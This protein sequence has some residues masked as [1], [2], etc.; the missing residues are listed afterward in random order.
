MSGLDPLAALSAAVAGAQSGVDIAALDLGVDI[1]LLQ[2]QIAIGDILEATVLP[3]QDGSDYVSLAGHTVPAQLPPGINP[4]QSIALQVT[5]FTPTALLVRNLGIA[6]PE[7]PIVVPELPA[8]DPA[9]PQA[10]ILTTTVPAAPPPPVAT[11][12][13]PTAPVNAGLPA[14]APPAPP[15][16]TVPPA[17]QAQPSAPAAPAPP[18]PGVVAPSPAVFA[19]AAVRQAATQRAAADA[20]LEEPVQRFA[21]DVEA[22]IAVAR[23]STLPPPA[24]RGGPSPAAPPPPQQASPPPGTLAPA[25]TLAQLNRTAVPPL[26]TQANASA[27]AAESTPPDPLAQ[28]APPQPPPSEPSGAAPRPLPATP[29]AAILARLRVP[30]SPLTLAAARTVTTAAQALSTTY[31]KLDALLASVASDPR[32]ATLRTLLDFAGTFD[33]RNARALP[34]QINA[35]VSNVVAGPESKLAQIVRAWSQ[36]TAAEAARVAEQNAP[37]ASAP[38]SGAPALPQTG[39]RAQSP[40]IPAPAAAATN[41]QAQAA[42]RTVALDHD[43]KTAI[44]ALIANPPRDASAQVVAALRD[45]LGATTAVQLNVLNA[46]A[47]DPSAITIPLPAFFFEG[48]RPAQLRINKDAPNGKGGMDADNFHIAFVLDTATLGTVAIDVQTVGRAVNVEVKTERGAAADRFKA[49]LGDLRSRLEG[50]RYTVSA[51]S[52]DVAPTSRTKDA[53]PPQQ[54]DAGASKTSNVDMRA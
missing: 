9:T 41:A 18:P 48:G 1:Q 43:V 33:L 10:A 30:E 15:A 36:A 7:T 16:P 24:A 40:A 37:A 26:V 12:A 45:A 25:S 54:V 20:S 44:L 4:G 28:D 2:T 53:K 6:T 46:Q 34:E 39:A 5:G 42:E 8:Q 27:V 31:A 51:I 13:N 47:N 29:E 50:L 17:S 23:A 11:P 19:A 49:T 22:R 38:A 35:F 3:P 32:A 21:D 14:A 52:A